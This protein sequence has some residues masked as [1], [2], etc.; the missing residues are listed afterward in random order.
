MTLKRFSILCCCR[1]KLLA[2]DLMIS[3]EF[4]ELI[5]PVPNPQEGM[6]LLL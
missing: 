6:T 2:P 4:P 3:Y 1:A 5:Y